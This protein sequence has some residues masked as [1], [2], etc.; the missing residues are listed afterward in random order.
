MK[1]SEFVS[2]QR[3]F[4]IG[5]LKVQHKT[6]RYAE[7]IASVTSRVFARIPVCPFWPD[8]QRSRDLRVVPFP[9]VAEQL[10]ILLRIDV[11]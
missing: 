7:Y 2:L 1:L 11:F 4:Q 10:P 6:H 5:Q 9:F 8:S 3:Y